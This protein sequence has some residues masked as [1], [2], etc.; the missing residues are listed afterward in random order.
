MTKEKITIL[1]IVCVILILFPIVVFAEGVETYTV[2]FNCMGGGN[3]GDIGAASGDTID[4]PVDPYYPGHIL[5][6]WYK[7][8]EYINEWNFDV[9]T[10]SKD[11]TLFAAW[12]DLYTISAASEDT[13]MGD[14]TGGGDYASG[15]S[16]T[17]SAIPKNGFRF[18]RWNYSDY[19]S[20]VYQLI[21][22]VNV[23]ITA[24]FAPI[25][26][27]SL[28]A[29]SSSYNSV[30]LSWTP[31]DCAAGYELYRCSQ[32]DGDY[33]KILT[34]DADDSLSFIDNELAT[35]QTYYYKVR[36]FCHCETADTYGYF[37]EP[38]SGVPKVA[39]PEV[40]A[41]SGG[42]RST[43]VSWDAVDG[44]SGYEIYRSATENGTYSKVYDF[45]FAEASCFTEYNLTANQRNYYKVLAYRTVDNN[46]YYSDFSDVQSADASFIAPVLHAGSASPNSVRLTWNALSGVNG[47]ELYMS[48]M[49][50]GVYRKI[51]STMMPP[52]AIYTNT[53]LKAGFTYYYRIRAIG[54]QGSK[55]IYGPYSQV[56][57]AVPSTTLT[58]RTFTILYQGDPKWGFSPDVRGN[59]CLMSSFAITINNMGIP[60]TPKT[61]FESNG[62]S[63]YIDYENLAVNFGVKAVCAVDPCSPY[64]RSYTGCGTYINSPASNGIAA[65]KE[66]LNKY[67]DGVICYFKRGD[68]AH[69]IVACKYDGDTIYYSDPGRTRKTLL[70]FNNTWVWYS[71]KMNYSNL[72][73]IVALDE[74]K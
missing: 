18:V 49:E 55:Y 35:D 10:V 7:E 16:V 52:T 57:S 54:K 6:A 34:A 21:A 41:A 61:V 62:N 73:Y 65:I 5:T 22:S 11:I 44:A 60:A 36:A 42:Y 27:P 23:N 56:V 4:K 45:P 17:L 26:T 14:V 28:T 53:K 70:T 69:A 12:K 19:A 15:A 43:K 38:I 25:G 8:E 3:I 46:T 32:Q 20:A 51:Y 30:T 1:I 74:I 47:Y 72:A 40:V 68:E 29:V 33:S 67:P 71:H 58:E 66:A 64:L 24:E 13:S 31:I 2:S 50:N 59:A 39:S 48:T 9:D 63:T 37:T